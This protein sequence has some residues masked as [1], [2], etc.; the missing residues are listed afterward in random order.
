ML[1]LSF[2]PPSANNCL[3]TIDTCGNWDT[4]P[5]QSN[6]AGTTK[7]RTNSSAEKSTHRSEGMSDLSITAFRP[8][9]CTSKWTE[10]LTV[11]LTL[12]GF[13]NSVTKVALCCV[14]F[15]ILFLQCYLNFAIGRFKFQFADR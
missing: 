13:F 8:G 15:R 12:E 11:L 14:Q 10:T 9:N 3:F 7:D 1:P 6:V 5:L 2:S 4:F